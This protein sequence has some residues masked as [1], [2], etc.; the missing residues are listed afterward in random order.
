MVL[1][2]PLAPLAAEGRVPRGPTV[3]VAAAWIAVA[4]PAPFAGGPRWRAPP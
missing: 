1:A 4:L 2:C 3:A